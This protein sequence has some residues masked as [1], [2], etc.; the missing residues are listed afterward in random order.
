[1]KVTQATAEKDGQTGR[2]KILVEIDSNDINIIYDGIR[3][4]EESGKFDP[5]DLKYK[6]KFD[7]VK[8]QVHETWKLLWPS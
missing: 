2:N 5:D 6:Q 7:H 1:M 4:L 8:Q 3:I